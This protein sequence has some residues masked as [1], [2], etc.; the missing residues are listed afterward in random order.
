MK[1]LSRKD[2]CNIIN[3]YNQ[4]ICLAFWTCSI[5]N[6]PRVNFVEHIFACYLARGSC[7]QPDFAMEALEELLHLCEHEGRPKMPLLAPLP[8]LKLPQ[9]W[10]GLG[11][12]GLGFKLQTQC[13]V[14]RGPDCFSSAGYSTGWAAFDGVCTISAI[15]A[16]STFYFSTFIR[17]PGV[18]GSQ[19]AG[20]RPFDQFIPWLIESRWFQECQGYIH[21]ANQYSQTNAL[22][23][24][25]LLV[26]NIWCLG[27]WSFSARPLA[28]SGPPKQ[29]LS[30]SGRLQK[31]GSWWSA[32]SVAF[33]LL[34]LPSKK[35]NEAD[36]FRP[37]NAPLTS[38]LLMIFPWN[39]LSCLLSLVAIKPNLKISH[40]FSC[41]A[42]GDLVI[43]KKR[44][45]SEPMRGGR[46]PS[47]EATWKGIPV[48]AKRVVAQLQRVNRRSAFVFV[49]STAQRNI[50]LIGGFT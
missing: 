46:S 34:R 27:L 36:D 31:A 5:Q 13:E 2:A 9:A 23:L 19:P 29:R 4:P 48:V 45:D 30:Q 1:H 26:A 33:W 12:I 38:E 20:R 39:L 50:L 42:A 14:F 6:L 40:F 47:V 22:Q 49:K 43:S 3:R 16:I 18:S 35:K 25:Q 41:W 44:L 32:W 11:I 10:L 21:Y 24:K 37:W 7:L 28:D 8:P 15:H 17:C